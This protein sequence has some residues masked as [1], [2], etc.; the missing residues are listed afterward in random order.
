MF[1]YYPLL[2]LRQVKLRENT[3]LLLKL[4]EV[5]PLMMS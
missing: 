1:K 2:Q 5:V 4:P 3:T